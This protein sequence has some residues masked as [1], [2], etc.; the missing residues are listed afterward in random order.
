MEL[1]DRKTNWSELKERIQ[2]KK[3]NHQLTIALIGKC[4]KRTLKIISII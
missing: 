4:I 2:G 1:S 3:T